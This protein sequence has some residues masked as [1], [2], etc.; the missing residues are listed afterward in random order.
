MQIPVLNGV[1]TNEAADFRVSYPYNLVPV[2]VDQ[3]ISQGYLRPAEGVTAFTGSGPGV[4]R[5]GINWN[6]VCYRV[7]GTS[8]VSIDSG[9]VISV[10]G[11]VAGTDQ[12]SFDYSFDFLAV[13]GGGN[14]YLWNGA[15]LV[16]NTDP[17]LGTVVDFIWVDGYFMTTDGSFLAVTELT[18]PFSVLPTKYGSS[19]VD[20]DPILA[21]LKLHNEPTAINRYTMETFSNIGGDGFPFSRIDGAM[22]DK[23]A[24]GTHA[25]C[26][27]MDNIAL[28]GGGRN[29][30]ISVYLGSN[31]QMTRIATR[32]IDLILASYTDETLAKVKIEPRVDKGH[33]LL[34]VH[35][36]DK[37]LVYDGAASAVT[38]DRV[39]FIVGSNLSQAQYRIRNFVRCYSQWLV[40]DTVNPVIGTMTTAV[41]THWGARIG[42]EF[43]TVALYNDGAGCIFHEL[44]LVALS[45]RVDLGVD[46]RISSGFPQVSLGRSRSD[47][48]GLIKGQ[49]NTGVFRNLMAI[50]TAGC[51]SRD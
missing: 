35:L 3:G 2:P 13:S 7:M 49:C 10:L 16:Q 5:G 9:G 41:S 37:T 24:V 30:A 17:D 51:L 38:N 36:P 18:N 44:E 11:A 22:I 43:S 21:L 23:G 4:D 47:W 29:E 6:G 1:Y 19:E 27:F 12:V 32:E 26:V 14:L 20:P 46:P 48:F 34:Y 8:L 45:G 33:Q 40:G 15:T 39:W 42:W 28:V 25:C 50:V 31:G